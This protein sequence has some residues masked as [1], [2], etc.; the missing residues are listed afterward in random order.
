MRCGTT[1][2]MVSVKRI[3]RIDGFSRRKHAYYEAVLEWTQR[4]AALQGKED[5]VHNELVE[6]G[7]DVG[8]AYQ[9]D[10]RPIKAGLSFVL[11]LITLGIYGLYVLYRMNP[12]WWKAQ[13]LEQDFDDKAFS[14]LDEARHHP[15]SH[16]LQ[17]RSKQG[18][19]LHALPD[20]LSRDARDLVSRLGLQGPYRS[21]RPLRRV[22]QRRGHSA[23]DGSDSLG[24]VRAGVISTLILMGVVLSG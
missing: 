23:A 5:E 7:D 20:P 11:T 13:V 17:E 6:L 19:Q 9:H 14:D 3:T 10:L 8:P 12:Y 22:P 21:G 24:G 2:L 16:R 4:Q 18:P 1:R 15:V